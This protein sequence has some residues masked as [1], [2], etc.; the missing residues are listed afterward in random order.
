[1]LLEPTPRKKKNKDE[2]NLLGPECKTWASSC[3][4]SALLVC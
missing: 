1:M 3:S 2:V 4:R